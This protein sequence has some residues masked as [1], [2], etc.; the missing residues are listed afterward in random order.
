MGCENCDGEKKCVVCGELYELKEGRCELKWGWLRA[1]G[2]VNTVVSVLRFRSLKFLLFAADNFWLY[3]YHQVEYP[4]FASNVFRTV[5]M[6]ET[7]KQEFVDPERLPFVAEQVLPSFPNYFTQMPEDKYAQVEGK[8]S[9]FFR[10]TLEYFLMAVPFTVLLFVVLNR[11]FYC[12]FQHELSQHLRMFSFWGFLCFMGMESNIE[13][14]AFLGFRNFLTM[15]SLRFAHKLYLAAFILGFFFVFLFA[16]AGFFLIHYCYGR[17]AKYFLDNV[18]RIKGAFS[19]MTLVYGVRPFLKGIIH[20]L[21]SR[22]NTLQLSLLASLEF[23][24][25]LAMVIY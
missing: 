21:L 11:V 17:L 6:I 4:W 3:E 10:S 5:R 24:V 18:Y 1:V 9:F 22:H 7:Q 2:L 16:F 25:C 12:L 8:D 23:L 13:F 19:L 15:G 20:A 14:F